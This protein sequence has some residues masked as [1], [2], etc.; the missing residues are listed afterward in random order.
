MKMKKYI[1][2]LCSSIVL[3][4]I[5]SCVKEGMDFDTNG[6][7]GLAF[8]HFVGKSQT[9]A[10]KPGANSLVITVSSTVK[11]DAPRTYNLIVNPNSTAKEGTQY[12]LSSKTV[13]IPAGQYSG[14]VTLTAN[15]D[16]LTPDAVTVNLSIDGEEAID[17]AKNYTISM[18]LFF[19]VT[20]DW[21]VGTWIW[22]DYLVGG[23]LYNQSEVEISKIDNNTIGIY[24]IW[25]GEMTIQATVDVTNAKIVIKP[26][27]KYILN[28]IEDGDDYG[29]LYMVA[30]PSDK[31]QG[32]V[33]TDPINGVCSYTKKISIE[34]WTPMLFDAGY[35]WGDVYTSTLTRP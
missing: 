23:A 19:E 27:Q 34:R 11:S 5:T 12:T 25:E 24:N 35:A 18:Y 9:L 20:M 14:T 13:T 22:S 33:R 17:Y 21:L 28:Y 8:V 16:K 31:W 26:S 32:Y 1:I 15:L 10:A 4:S 6:G 29:S 3:L 7:K 30:C 2:L